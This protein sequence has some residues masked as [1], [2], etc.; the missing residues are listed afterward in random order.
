MSSGEKVEIAHRVLCDDRTDLGAEQ[1][2]FRDDAVHAA[3]F[4]DNRAKKEGKNSTGQAEFKGKASFF[5]A[6]SGVCFTRP[7]K[8]VEGASLARPTKDDEGEVANF[9]RGTESRSTKESRATIG[10]GG[11]ERWKTIGR[12]MGRVNLS[13]LGSVDPLC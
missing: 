1:V 7:T 2:V 6:R 13:C 5:D 10:N 9:G 3:E 8:N 12:E 4:G 11:E